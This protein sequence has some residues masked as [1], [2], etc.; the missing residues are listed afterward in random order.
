MAEALAL[1]PWVLVALAATVFLGAL[2][3]RLAG[4]GYGMVTAP[5]M[6][7]LAPGF[8]PTTVLATGL[9][10]GLSGVAMDR[11]A[12]AL[13]ELPPGFAGRTLGAVLAAWLALHIADTRWFGPLIAGVVY[14]GIALS[15]AGLRVAI[16]PGTLF[17]SGAVAGVMG[18]LT[19]VGAPPMALLY[20]HEEA[21][22]AAAMQNTFYLFGMAVSLVALAVAGLVGGKHLALSVLLAPPAL[23]AVVLARPLS[24]RFARASLRPVAL[25]LAGIAATALLAQSF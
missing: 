17:A 15:L 12:L 21:R 16:R 18:T 25:T 20:Q 24:A 2:L 3:Q 1:G 5:V 23:L 6:A 11:R 8:L 10:F 7:M 4:Q 14:L 19:G 9:I 22:R 13:D